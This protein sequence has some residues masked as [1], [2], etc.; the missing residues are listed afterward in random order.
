MLGKL[1]WGRFEEV[2]ARVHVLEHHPN[3]SNAFDTIGYTFRLHADILAALAD[4]FTYAFP[5]LKHLT[6][7][8]IWTCQ[9]IATFSGPHVQQ[10]QVTGFLLIENG[11]WEE[12]LNFK[13]E[14][15]PHCLAERVAGTLRSLEGRCPGVEIDMDVDVGDGDEDILANICGE[16]IEVM[17]STAGWVLASHR[18]LPGRLVVLEGKMGEVARIG[19]HKEL[20]QDGIE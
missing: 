8:C 6:W 16:V 15:Y 7:P 4:R 13:H 17:K 14:N 9:D 12:T 18:S 3:S 5:N 19:G 1:N 20:D 10:I 2:A 11:G